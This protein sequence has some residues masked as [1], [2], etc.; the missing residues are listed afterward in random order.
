VRIK[1]AIQKPGYF[2]R[3]TAPEKRVPGTLFISYGGSIRLE[4]FGSFDDFITEITTGI[5]IENEPVNI[6]GFVEDLQFVKLEKCYYKNKSIKIGNISKFELI[7]NRAMTGFLEAPGGDCLFNSC[8]FSIEGIDEWV[9]LSGITVVSNIEKKSSIVHYNPMEDI[10]IVT[11]ENM[12]I[13]ITFSWKIPFFPTIKNASVSQKTYFNLASD[14]QQPLEEFIHV[15]AKIT[16]LLC[17]AIN[18]TVSIDSFQAKSDLFKMRIKDDVF[19]SVP[20]S[21]YY[22]SIPYSATIAEI[23]DLTMLFRYKNIEPNLSKAFQNWINA[24]DTYSPVF[25]LYFYAI[26]DRQNSL[27][28]H[29]LDLAHAIETY[30]RRLSTEKL[31]NDSEFS[32]LCRIV[33]EN[34]PEDHKEWL[35]KD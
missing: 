19:V 5:G 29:F 28:G 1:E 9:G 12:R 7:V 25:Y 24:Y 20:I 3:P 2:W 23:N 35:K 34:C 15:A 31:M 8:K 22:K 16:N 10:D 13:S 33:I 32:E 26:S 11:I 14:K 4:L 6:I 18:K 27:E 30:H 21:I 17:F